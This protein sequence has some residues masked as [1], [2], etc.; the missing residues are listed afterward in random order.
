[1]GFTLQKAWRSSDMR[2]NI[3][4]SLHALGYDHSME[5]RADVK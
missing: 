4:G 5:K 2:A 1:M 3:F